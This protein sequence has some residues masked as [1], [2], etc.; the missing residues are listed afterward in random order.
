MSIDS[1]GDLSCLCLPTADSIHAE[2]W[3][4]L[5]VAAPP[6]TLPEAEAA[7]PSLDR[8]HGHHQFGWDAIKMAA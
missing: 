2:R 7:L 5:T 3:A 4:L 6:L 1:S 8:L